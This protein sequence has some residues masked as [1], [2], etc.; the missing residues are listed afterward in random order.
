MI[1]A[2]LFDF[3]YVLYLPQNKGQLNQELLRFVTVSQAQFAS[4]IFSASA[5]QLLEQLRPELVPPFVDIFSSKKLGL[6]KYKPQ[7][8]QQLA[9]K[10]KLSPQ[11]ILFTDDRIENIRAA[12]E[13]GWQTIHFKN[14]DYFLK[15]A[16]KLLQRL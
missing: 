4:Y 16:K 1:K 9:K 15:K 2:L 3:S 14:T 13:A 12:R 11:Q 6:S 10:L 5:P 8:Y 7:A